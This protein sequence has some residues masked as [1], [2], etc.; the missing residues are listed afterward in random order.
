MCH[1]VQLCAWMFFVVPLMCRNVPQCA[2][3]FRMCRMCHA[4]GPLPNAP[5][6]L[7]LR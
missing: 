7:N 3:L 6:K 5:Q 2:L 1:N 4:W